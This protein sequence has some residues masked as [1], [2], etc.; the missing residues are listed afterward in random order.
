MKHVIYHTFHS[1]GLF[2]LAAALS[3]VTML[4]LPGANATHAEPNAGV[5]GNGTPASCTEAALTA[6]LAG[7][8]NVTFNCGG[9]AT[10]LVLKQQT[11][12]Q[13]TTIDGGGVITLT[14]ALASKLFQ[15][16]PG[17]RL[18]LRN[19]TLDGAFSI[20]DDGAAIRALGP[21]ALTNV[22]VQNSIASSISP[23]APA[24]YCGGAIFLASA[25]TIRN[26]AFI[27][28]SA[29]VGGGAICARSSRADAVIVRDSAFTNNLGLYVNGDDLNGNGLGGAIFADAASKISVVDS[30][31]TGNRARLGGAVYVGPSASLEMRGTPTD[32]LFASKLRFSNNDARDHGG[33]IYNIGD[34]SMSY[35]LL[36]ENRVPTQ[37][38]V[39]NS[40]GA[41]YNA[42]VVMLTHALLVRN[43]ADNGGGMYVS[44]N[45]G[46]GAAQAMIERTSFI[47]NT[48]D[49]LGGGL[50]AEALT[51]TVTISASAF[52]RNT[53]RIAGG[54]AADIDARLNVYNSSFTSNQANDGGGLY[55]AHVQPTTS[56]VSI[57]SSTFSGNTATSQKGGGLYNRGALVEV[58]NVTLVNNSNGLYNTDGGDPDN[59]GNVHLR[60]TVLD[61]PG[62]PNCINMGTGKITD[63]G[64]NVSTDTSCPLSAPSSQIGTALNPALGP[65]TADTRGPTSYHMPLE[66]SPLIDKGA[67]CPTRDQISMARAGECDIGAMEFGGMPPTPPVTPTPP[68]TP[69]PPVTPS[70][71]VTP[72]PPT[73]PAP[74]THKVSLPVVVR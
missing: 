41:I 46:P 56:S 40:G 55:V 50:Y 42:G 52:H 74:A 7:G 39:A 2:K 57:H 73:P 51:T 8:G 15:S 48:S 4:A 38:A 59:G 27:N 36:T 17:V 3:L 37:T 23:Q 31:F 18:D 53:A 13:P 44:K 32:T 16:M 10:I 64:N 24:R 12:A 5:V 14:G 22:T 54:G 68:I 49:A 25:A 6:A 65:L 28:N 66:G 21:L 30:S 58:L 43:E 60:N 11:I 71:S 9:P 47:R 33:A 19:I 61:N 20:D 70:P 62:T 29:L 35:A 69:V 1:G 45:G 26:S 34:L 72:M 63:D 67:N